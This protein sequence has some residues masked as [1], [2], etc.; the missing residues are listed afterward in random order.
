MTSTVPADIIASR[1]MGRGEPDHEVRALGHPGPR[2]LFAG[3]F[4]GIV[5]GCGRAIRPNAMLVATPR[6]VQNNRLV[7]VTTTINR[8]ESAAG[9]SLWDS[10]AS[11]APIRCGS[12]IRPRPS[13]AAHAAERKA[14]RP[15]PMLVAVA[16]AIHQVCRG[17][18]SGTG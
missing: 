12:A 13:T 16:V 15:S 5:Y 2:A 3:I 10:G 9:T 7:S 4:A 8:W 11:G 14:S 1:L 6:S 17:A 18:S